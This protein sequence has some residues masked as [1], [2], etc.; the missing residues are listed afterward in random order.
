MSLEIKHFRAI[1]VKCLDGFWDNLE[2]LRNS[3][4]YSWS[5]RHYIQLEPITGPSQHTRCEWPTQKCHTRCR[6]CTWTFWLICTSH[7]TSLIVL[8]HFPDRSLGQRDVEEWFHQKLKH[9][10]VEYLFQ[11][12]VYNK[13]STAI[14]RYSNKQSTAINRVQLKWENILHPLIWYHCWFIVKNT[15]R[16]ESRALI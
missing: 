9:N 6:S 13:Q 3:Q 10:E 16:L 14:N 7:T 4:W 12:S 8:W 15:S 11:Y 2:L 5:L 1:F